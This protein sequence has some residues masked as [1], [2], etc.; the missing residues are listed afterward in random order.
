M[1]TYKDLKTYD[2]KIIQ[3]IIPLKEDAKHF[4]QKLWKRH[5]SLEPLVK[6]ELNKL[7]VAK[8]IFLVRHTTWVENLV[9]ARKKSGDIR[10][11]IDFRKLNWA[12]LKDNYPILAM[13]QILQ[14]GSRYAM[15]YLLY[16]FSRYNQVLV[17]KEDCVKMAFQTKWGT[18]SYDKM[19]FRLI[20][21]GATFQ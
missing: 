18:Y 17:A 11:C 10:I 15:L 13:Y 20:N 2:T 8:I 14:S 19:P 1:W 6:K 21:A 5:P 12:S 4:Q 16:L 9:P 3:H 7:L